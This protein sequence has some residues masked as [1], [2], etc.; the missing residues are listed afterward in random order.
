MGTSC[1]TLLR[2]LPAR[3]RAGVVRRVRRVG[4]GRCVRPANAVGGNVTEWV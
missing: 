1:A 3:V 4:R 2:A